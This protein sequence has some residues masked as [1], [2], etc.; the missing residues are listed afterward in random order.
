M[1]P[2]TELGFNV[3]RFRTPRPYEASTWIGCSNECAST[4]TI[5]L[6]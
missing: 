4:G 6:K 2:G 3:V 1:K 5:V